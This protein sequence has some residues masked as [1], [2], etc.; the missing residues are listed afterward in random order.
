MRWFM[1]LHILCNQARIL[2]NW[3]IKDK[4]H[5]KEVTLDQSLVFKVQLSPRM[6]HFDQVY[7]FKQVEK[8]SL[9]QSTPPSD[10]TS[11]M[12]AEF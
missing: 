11:L 5:L 4:Q 2:R 1:K 3:G 10:H 6:C 7:P 9:T 8:K 12:P